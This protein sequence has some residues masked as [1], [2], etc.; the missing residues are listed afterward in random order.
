MTP[1]LSTDARRAAVPCVGPL[2]LLIS[3]AS[4]AV[5]AA[6]PGEVRRDLSRLPPRALPEVAPAAAPDVALG[7]SPP[8]V[9]T[10]SPSALLEEAVLYC[11]SLLA[12]LL[13]S[14]AA[15]VWKLASLPLLLPP[16]NAVPPC[17]DAADMKDAP[18][19][20]GAVA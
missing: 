10:G 18:P 11:D 5:P 12:G 17:W 2:L 16:P 14:D 4:S 3:A 19:A 9:T 20:E 15:A 8:G 1:L 6:D 7:V 13:R